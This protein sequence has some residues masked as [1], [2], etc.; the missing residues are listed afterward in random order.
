MDCGREVERELLLDQYHCKVIQINKVMKNNNKFFFLSIPTNEY[1]VKH[2]LKK[3]INTFAF[4][5]LPFIL[6]FSCKKKK[7]K[8]KLCLSC[9]RSRVHSSDRHT[10]RVRT[11]RPTGGGPPR[12]GDHGVRGDLGLWESRSTHRRTES[13]SGSLGELKRVKRKKQHDD[14]NEWRQCTSWPIVFI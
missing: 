11:I 14:V 4:W 1:K 9:R 12:R 10:H 6:K 2:I 7:P 13:L 8:D 3:T 5:F